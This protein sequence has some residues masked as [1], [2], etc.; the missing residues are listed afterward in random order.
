M[1]NPKNCGQLLLPGKRP[2]LLDPP[3]IRRAA[4]QIDKLAQ[5]A[6]PE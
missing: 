5:A 6:T 1:I 3:A 2:T 4:F